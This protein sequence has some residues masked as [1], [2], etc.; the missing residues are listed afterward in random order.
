M[1]T[2]IFKNLIKAMR[3][4]NITSIKVNKENVVLTTSKNGIFID[5][6]IKIKL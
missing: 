1:D 3:K 4:N 2:P 6:D 5:K